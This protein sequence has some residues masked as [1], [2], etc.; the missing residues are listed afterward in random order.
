[1]KEGGYS[2]LIMKESSL[3]SN[4]Y[5]GIGLALFKAEKEAEWSLNKF[6]YPQNS[7]IDQVLSQKVYGIIKF[8]PVMNQ[9]NM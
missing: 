4:D 8:Y 1:M 2:L 7:D 6:I 9:I 3:L 5:E